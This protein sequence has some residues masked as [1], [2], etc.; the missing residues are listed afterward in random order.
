[1]TKLNLEITSPTGIIFKGD[2]HMAVVPSINGEI[3][4]MQGHES[5]ISKLKEGK[6]SVFDEQENLVKS[7]DVVSGFAEMQG[8][9]KLLV[10]ID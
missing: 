10:L 8:S 2:C 9:D 3:G 7:F 5:V 6:I 4:V 1:M